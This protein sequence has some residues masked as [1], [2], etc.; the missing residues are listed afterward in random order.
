MV[1]TI[2]QPAYAHHGHPLEPSTDSMPA[3]RSRLWHWCRS[4]PAHDNEVHSRLASKVPASGLIGA[5]DRQ[6]SATMTDSVRVSFSLDADAHRRDPRITYA[7]MLR[8]RYH[9]LPRW[10]LAPTQVPRG[11]VGDSRGTPSLRVHNARVERHSLSQRQPGDEAA[12]C[13]QRTSH[14]ESEVVPV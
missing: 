5:S 10:R 8:D 11:E 13:N 7:V 9:E 6:S 1:N 3:P 2:A 4:D 12:G 14:E